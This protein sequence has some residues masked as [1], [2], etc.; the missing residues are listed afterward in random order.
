ME[1]FQD[2]KSYAEK[3]KTQPALEGPTV[4]WASKLNIVY[5]LICIHTGIHTYMHTYTCMHTHSTGQSKPL[6]KHQMTHEQYLIPKLKVH[7]L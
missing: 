3:N 1:P 6:E 4:L 2:S 5:Y 7:I